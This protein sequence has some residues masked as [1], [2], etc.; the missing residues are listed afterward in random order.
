MTG[1]DGTIRTVYASDEFNQFF[2]DTDK[3]VQSKLKFVIDVIQRVYEIP[4]KY[5]KKLVEYNLYEM[6][7][8]TGYNEY[9]TILFAVDHENIIQ[10]TKVILLNSFL[11]K[12]NKDYKAQIRIAE[13]II[14]SM[15]YDTNR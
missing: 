5:V 12:S 14:K 8:S 15:E 1:P 11:K 4:T 7:I 6:R 10:S 3:R 9:R 13:R 2:H